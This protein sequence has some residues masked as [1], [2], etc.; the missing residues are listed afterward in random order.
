MKGFIGISKQKLD[1]IV[2]TNSLTIIFIPPY[3]TD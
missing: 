3:P 1:F 2:T